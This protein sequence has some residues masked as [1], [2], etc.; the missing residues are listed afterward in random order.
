MVCRKLCKS[1]EQYFDLMTK[2]F[3]SQCP[4][5]SIN[6]WWAS[7]LIKGFDVK[8]VL[9]RCVSQWLSFWHL[10]VLTLLCY[11]KFYSYLYK[12]NSGKWNPTFNVE[13]N[14]SELNSMVIFHFQRWIQPFKVIFNHLWSPHGFTLINLHLMVIHVIIHSTRN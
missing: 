12:M 2:L 7:Q 13:F 4:R 10:V 8:K 14:H 5:V 9:F 11:S 1:Y 6:K 3:Q